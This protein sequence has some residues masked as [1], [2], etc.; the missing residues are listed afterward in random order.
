M[1]AV[2]RSILFLQMGKHGSLKRT[3]NVGP[4]DPKVLLGGRKVTGQ[5]IAPFGFAATATSP[6]GLTENL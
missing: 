3:S 6:G 1:L 4:L 2:M 5:C